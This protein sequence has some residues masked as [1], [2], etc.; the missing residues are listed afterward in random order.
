[1]N[2]EKQK[3]ALVVALG[4]IVLSAIGYYIYNDLGK[5]DSNL[6]NNTDNITATSTS[7][8]LESSSI[9]LVGEGVKD[10]KVEVLP[11]G[12][13][14]PAIP[15]L[16][17]KVLYDKDLSAEVIKILRGNIKTSRNLL[18]AD[19]N[20][21]N[22]WILL[23]TQY[24]T[25]GDFDK[26]IEAWDYAGLLSPTN[27][28]SFQ[29]LGD[30][31]G[32]YLEDAQKGEENFLKAI[33]NSPNDIYLYFKIADFYKDVARDEAKRRVIVEQGLKANPDSKELKDLLNSL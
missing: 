23:G 7:D 31:Y 33:E 4:L 9:G 18:K 6:G 30:L 12:G 3:M 17:S 28:V 5:R 11:L 19:S 29:N 16:D 14:A 24:K 20:L 13:S 1:V 26:T 32:Y 22:T 8:L 27:S 21:I 25:A 15:D 10:A 2:T